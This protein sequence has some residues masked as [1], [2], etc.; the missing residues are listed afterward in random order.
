MLNKF[1]TVLLWVLLFCIA[2]PALAKNW[3]VNAGALGTG[4][5]YGGYSDIDGFFPATLTIN[6]GDTVTFTYGGYQ[7]NHNVVSDT[8]LF[9]CANGCDGDGAGGNGNPATGWTATIAF[10]N[11]GTFGYHCEVHQSMG[12]VGTI[13]VN[14][15]TPP[16][17]AFAITPG[18]TGSWYNNTQS[19]HG[20]NVEVLAN[21]L[22]VAVWYVFD[23]SGNNLWLTGVGNY[24]GNTAA[25]TVTQVTGGFFP[26]AF[27]QTKIVRGN[28]GTLTMTFT[29]CNNGTATWAPIDTVHFSAPS[30][31][32]A[33]T[34]LTSVGGLAC[35]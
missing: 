3:T 12:M 15:A 20:F 1:T 28:W 22:M 8:G 31:P 16:P 5:Y 14:A 24:S 23:S 32:F 33:I 18:I 19:G 30:S 6:A 2:S 26:P 10:N 35:P 13:T 25:L 7:V 27:D 9:R 29:D 21:N 17:P 4:G 11:A 34:R